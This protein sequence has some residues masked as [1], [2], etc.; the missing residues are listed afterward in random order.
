MIDCYA[1]SSLSALN[2]GLSVAVDNMEDCNGSW[3]K[4]MEFKRSNALP[5]NS[6]RSL[7]YFSSKIRYSKALHV[8]QFWGGA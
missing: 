2:V 7:H 6:Q 3:K 4:A 8:Y 5:V 1:C